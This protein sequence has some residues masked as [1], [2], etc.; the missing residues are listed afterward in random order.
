MA[1]TPRY[2]SA[3]AFR[4][5]LEDRLRNSRNNENADIARLRKQVAFDRLLAR[6]FD[7][8]EPRWILKG[9]YA[10][11]L[12][13]GNIARATQDIDFS[14]PRLK[15]PDPEKIREYLEVESRKD[16]SDWF[17]Y[18]IG[19]AV[20]EFEQAVYGG[21]RFPV[22]ALLDGRKFASFRLDVG[23]GDA[24]ISEPEWKYGHDFLSFAGIPP[25]RVALLPLAQQFAEKAHA[26]TVPRKGNPNSRT[27][28]LVDMVL[29]IERGA[30]DIGKVKKSINATFGRRNTHSVPLR[31]SQPPASWSGAYAALAR[32]CGVERKTVEEAFELLDQ[33]WKQLFGL[34]KEEP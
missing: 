22:E 10:L 18:L 1:D 30:L 12:R 2:Q 29:L 17:Q 28:D 6:L 27:R 21:W 25:A 9:G 8:P 24:V 32:D 34:E 14:T 3:S 13:L 16:K 19:A 23:I 31:L 15:D 7:A 11:E 33:Y 5:A 20:R 4:R 26:Y